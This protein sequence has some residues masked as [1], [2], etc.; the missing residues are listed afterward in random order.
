MSIDCSLRRS[1]PGT[2]PP[3]GALC[4]NVAVNRLEKLAC[5]A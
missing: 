1:R 3:S 4:F 2:G 5:V